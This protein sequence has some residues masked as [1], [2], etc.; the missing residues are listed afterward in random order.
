MLGYC[1]QSLL[2]LVLLISFAG[3]K[4]YT[5][6]D[7]QKRLPKETQRGRGVFACYIDDETYIARNH[8]DAIYDATNGYLY[9][10]STTNEFQFRLFVYE[11]LFSTGVYAFSVTGE[12][13]ILPGSIQLF[14][15][16]TDSENFLEIT[17]IDI[18][19]QIIAGTFK[20]N[21]YDENGT[22][23]KTVT[24]GRFDLGME[25]LD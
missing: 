22:L 16:E 9:I 6:K 10:N 5:I 15:V 4:K 2:V 7:T 25:I 1:K 8:L 20:M 19:E 18:D 24:E 11:G 17:K 3:C 12:E 14:G 23:F 13:Y 21:L